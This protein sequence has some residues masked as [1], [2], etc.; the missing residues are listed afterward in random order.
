MVI[1]TSL[2]IS[3]ESKKQLSLL[4]KEVAI[5]NLPGFKIR[6]NEYFAGIGQKIICLSYLNSSLSVARSRNKFYTSE[7]L[8][9]CKIPVP[10]CILLLEKDKSKYKEKTKNLKLPLVVK[11]ASGSL[12]KGITLGVKT[13]KQI[14]EALKYALQYDDQ[15]IIEEFIPNMLDYRITF[16]KG[17]YLGALLAAPEVVIG[18]G[19]NTVE[20]LIDEYNHTRKTKYN[21]PPLTHEWIFKT[22]LAQYGY[23]LKS[24]PPKDKVIR[25][26]GRGGIYE[27]ATEKVH[28]ENIE[29][30]R[31][32]CQVMGLKFAG[33]DFMSPDASVPYHKNGALINEINSFPHLDMYEQ[34]IIGKKIPLAKNIVKLMFPKDKDAWIPIIANNKEITNFDELKKH[35]KEKPKEVELKDP[36]RIIKNA[37]LPLLSYLINSK[38]TKI[39]IK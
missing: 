33:V 27:N 13:E 10:K 23:D 19:T 11:P 14:K 24:I 7:I 20:H 5:R 21:L 38:T 29:L 31:S 4:L 1:K 16:Y 34:I 22:Y 12:A 37:P 36:K 30:C 6:E 18:D 9:N 28:P 25:I 26:Y 39:K 3:K 15:L 8:K 35:L 2:E 32:A 17:K